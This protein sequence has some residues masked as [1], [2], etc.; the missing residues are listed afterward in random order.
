[1]SGSFVADGVSSSAL[2]ICTIGVYTKT[3]S[4]F[5]EQLVKARVDSFCDVRNRR[6]MRGS[7]Y[8]FVNSA[9]L[10]ARLAA[11][12]IHYYHFRDLAPSD[13]IRQAQK[14]QDEAS[15]IGKRSRVT[16]SVEFKRL[17]WE[18][19]L[20]KFSSIDFIKRLSPG[21]TK[22][23]LFCVEADHR[24]CHR[25]LLADRLSMDLG[26]TITHL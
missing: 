3:E 1:M 25:S 19:C 17:Y 15:G 10:Q 24:A 26:S 21:A 14:L 6:G 8:A 18:E 23:A 16:L 4:Q 22:I 20:S 5:F 7:L 12:R 11:Q 13:K 9:R 2:E